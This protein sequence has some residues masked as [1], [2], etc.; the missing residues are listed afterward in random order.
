MR[1]IFYSFF[2]L[3][4]AKRRKLPF[5][6]ICIIHDTSVIFYRALCHQD[7]SVSSLN[8]Y[9]PPKHIYPNFVADGS[10]KWK[11]EKSL[12]SEYVAIE[13]L[14]KEHP[15]REE[16]SSVEYGWCV[17]MGKQSHSLPPHF[18]SKCFF[19]SNIFPDTLWPAVK[20]PSPE[21]NLQYLPINVSEICHM[22]SSDD[23]H[24]NSEHY[25]E[26]KALWP[27]PKSTMLHSCPQVN[28]LSTLS[29]SL[30]TYK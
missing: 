24:F 14:P 25:F 26:V 4:E 10:L 15:G 18:A 29:L 6:Y 20:W 13:Q 22:A 3:C 12:C 7:Y 16:M 5:V 2:T 11:E 17:L 21:S 8:S 27:S 23:V 28:N 9:Q 30:L 19:L 1:N